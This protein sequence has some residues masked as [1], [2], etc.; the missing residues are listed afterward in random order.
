[1][2][3][4]QIGYAND[5]F[6]RATGYA[7]EELHSISPLDLVTPSF[8]AELPTLTERLRRREMVRAKTILVRRD[9]TT[10]PV[11][12]AAAPIVSASGRVTHIVGLLRDLTEELRLSEQ[13][14]HS[15]RL[16]AIGEF[17][18]GV[19]H[20]VN[21]PLQ[22]IIGTLGVLLSEP[23]DAALRGDLELVQREARRAGRIIR[24]L[25]A[26]VRRSPG[27]RVLIEVNETIQAAVSV[28]AYE[29]EQAG[30]DL[31]EQYGANLPLVLASRDDLQQV[32]AN[33]IINA[34][35]AI[36]RGGGRGV[37]NV[38]TGVSG[39][40]ALIEVADDGPGVPP[41]LVGRLFEPFS[42]SKTPGEG[43]GLGLSIAFAIV[44]AH[45]GSL[46]LV[47]SERGACFRVTLPGAGFPGPAAVH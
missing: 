36:A 26:F 33:L 22:S 35:Q 32:V 27:A 3:G 43:T 20:E 14:V 21:N 44:N 10:F 9:G 7:S 25:L 28:R 38:R 8:R 29:F 47:P 42:T 46:E 16:S 19:A 13:L 37:L 5:A 45:G 41:E 18:S 30:V 31:K 24:N 17:V 1:V 40:H 15:E 23:K 11:E 6:C 39:D 34:Q 4:A 12:W 2:R